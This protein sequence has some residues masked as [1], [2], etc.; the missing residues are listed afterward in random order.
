MRTK[1]PIHKEILSKKERRVSVM[2]ENKK[3]LQRKIPDPVE[4]RK[5]IRIV[6]AE[7]DFSKNNFDESFGSESSFEKKEKLKIQAETETYYEIV[8][9]NSA[10]KI[11]DFSLYEKKSL[12]P[13]EYH[14]PK[15][16][17]TGK[18]TALI[19]TERQVVPSYY[20]DIKPVSYRGFQF[21]KIEYIIENDPKIDGFSYDRENEIVVYKSTYIYAFKK[22]GK[23]YDL[24]TGKEIPTELITSTNKVR[25]LEDYRV[26]YENLE[27]IK[28]HVAVY[29]SQL[30]TA[31]SA[32]KVDNKNKRE[33]LEILRKRCSDYEEKRRKFLECQKAM[34]QNRRSEEIEFH[35][36]DTEE[37]KEKVKQL[38]VEIKRRL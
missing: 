26:M 5:G 37:E 19:E 10:E 28:E 15:Q 8:L 21:E 20:C 38:V 16:K 3:N 34:L 7:T 32:L 30:E 12:K 17:T 22:K 9:A 23:F 14:L 33:A 29:K 31:L 4:T 36:Y 11:F 18:Y 2:A 13:T 35:E 6:F 24:I 27:G 25:F 1:F